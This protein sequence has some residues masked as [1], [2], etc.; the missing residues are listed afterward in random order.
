MESGRVDDEIVPVLGVRDV[1]EQTLSRIVAAGRAAGMLASP[2]T[3]GELDRLGVSFL[4]LHTNDFLRLGAADIAAR[5]RSTE[6]T[7]S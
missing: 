4:Y 6:G 3:I 7:V 5:C 2:D 1:V